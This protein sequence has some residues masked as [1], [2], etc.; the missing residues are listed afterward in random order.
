MKCP[1]CGYEDSRVI[2]SRPIN[3]N[4]VVRR[5]REC[6]GC[7]RRFTTYERFEKLPLMV[8]KSDGRR[9]EFDRN[10]VREGIL[11]ACEKRP[12][13]I[14]T[15]DGIVSDIEYKLQDYIMEV[16]SSRIGRMVLKKLYDLDEV[17]YVR[18][19]SVY[20]QFASIGSFRRE[21]T[22]LEGRKNPKQYKKA[23][24]KVEGIAH[25]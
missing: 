17:A 2:D 22:R 14:D 1:H 23:R 18:F 21:L 7:K 9:E 24:K 3:E 16:P 5:R 8:I 25:K 12:I 13:S 20:R 4:S 19:A 10:K 15:I 6:L 11:R